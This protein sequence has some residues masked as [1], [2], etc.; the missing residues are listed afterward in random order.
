M[1]VRGTTVMPRA[2]TSSGARSAVES[3]TIAT[4]GIGEAARP[5]SALRRAAAL[6]ARL[7]GQV[8]EVQAVDEIPENRQAVFV[9]LVGDLVLLVLL[10]DDPCPVQHLGG[11]E[12]RT[13]EADG[14][15]D[16][17]AGP[18]VDVELT[19]VLAEVEPGEEHLFGERGDHDPADGDPELAEG[20]QHQVVSDRALWRHALDLHGDGVGLERADPDREIAIGLLLLQD[21]DVLSGL[22]M[23]RM[24]S[25]LTSIRSSVSTAPSALV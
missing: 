15:R 23:H 3:V 7:V 17:I 5:R 20:G 10:R 22:Q 8:G 2:S 11:H 9:Q 25:T 14:K 1:T 21:H 6:A 16:G 13:A 12:D 19:A 24:L 18:G 4:L